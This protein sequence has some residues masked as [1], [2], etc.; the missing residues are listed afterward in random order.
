MKRGHKFW[1]LAVGLM[2][3]LALSACGHQSKK[4]YGQALQSRKPTVWLPIDFR[5][6]IEQTGKVSMDASTEVPEIFVVKNGMAVELSA[7]TA[8][9]SLHPTYYSRK[10][11]TVRSF[12]KALTLG[13][14]SKMSTDQIIAKYEALDKKTYKYYRKS[15]VDNVV[16]NGNRI[17]TDD[18]V[19]N[20]FDGDDDVDMRINYDRDYAQKYFNWLQNTASG[21]YV[22]PTPQKVKAYIAPNSSNNKGK[23]AIREKVV[24]GHAQVWGKKQ[25]PID[26]AEFDRRMGIPVQDSNSGGKISNMSFNATAMPALRNNGWWM[27]LSAKPDR[28]DK[29]IGSSRF[30]GFRASTA[31]ILTPKETF[32][33]LG[34]SNTKIQLDKAGDKGVGKL[35][36][37]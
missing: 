2:A 13:Q 28:I 10:D 34:T 22:A 24:F 32:K 1:A 15:F 6:Q 29:K 12:D 23:T 9:D 35:H 17:M 33:R 8:G 31:A 7:V 30:Y 4:F 25:M 21:D 37:R 5:A 11:W 18:Y 27:E 3:V 14:L 19:E 20:G 16:A 26:T 36:I